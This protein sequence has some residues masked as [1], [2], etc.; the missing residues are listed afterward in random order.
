MQKQKQEE[1]EEKKHIHLSKHG[2]MFIDS[3]HTGPAL[4]KNRLLSIGAAV[5]D[6]DKGIKLETF[7]ISLKIDKEDGRQNDENT[8]KWWDENAVK[9]NVFQTLCDEAIDPVDAMKT[10]ISFLNK[11][12]VYFENLY[13]VSDYSACDFP[14]IEVYLQQLLGFEKSLS[15]VKNNDGSDGFRR[16]FGIEDFLIY[17]TTNILHI[18][19]IYPTPSTLRRIKR[20]AYEHSK[21]TDKTNHFPDV[22][23]LWNL[24]YCDAYIQFCRATQIMQQRHIIHQIRLQHSI[25]THQYQRLHSHVYQYEHPCEQQYGYQYEYPREQQYEHQY[26][27]QYE[28]PREQQYEHQNKPH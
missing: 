24:F 5:L 19:M 11:Y 28:Y 2:V 18:P 26:E 22:D 6:L 3:E 27:P 4:L 17:A 14:Y 16:L 21:R 9:R 10:F 8:M 7:R 20:V 1:T 13:L 12:Q 15:Y 23:A 25:Q